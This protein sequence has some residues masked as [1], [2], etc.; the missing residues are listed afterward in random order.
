MALF[1]K[2]KK[3]ELT[4]EEQENVRVKTFLD[5]VE[6]G[7]I[8]FKEE[9]IV[10]DSMYRCIWA[11]R[12]Y[13]TTTTEQAILSAFGERSGVTLHVIT[14][15]LSGV[16]EEKLIKNASNRT[17][18]VKN[19]VT[20]VQKNITA[21]E[22]YADIDQ[23][24]RQLHRE[25]ESLFNTSV[26]IEI[27]AREWDEFRALQT[28]VGSELKRLKISYD[29]LKL[30]QKD[31]FFSV[32]PG[33]TDRFSG[34]Y[35]RAL[36]ASSVAN[37]YPFLFSGK[38]CEK[39]FTLG[40]D[41]SGGTVIMDFNERS[42][43]I[44]NP[45]I[46]ILGMPGMGKSFAAKTI[47][48]N[49]ALQ[50]MNIIV[51]DPENEYE[52]LT[53]N[54]GGTYLDLMSG[55][56]IINVLEPKT[57]TTAD[58]GETINDDS[59]TTDTY[60]RKG[61][62]SQH[63]SFL[64]DFFKTYKNLSLKQLDALEII[65]RDLYK[66][67]GFD[68][69]TDFSRVPKTAFPILSDLWDY[70]NYQ[71]DHFDEAS[72]YYEKSVLRDLRLALQSICEGTQ[73][74]Y[75]NGHTNITNAHILTFGMKGILDADAS[76]RGAMLFNCLSYLSDMMLNQRNTLGMIDELYLFLGNGTN[77]SMTAC[78]YIR[79]LSK[80]CRKFDSSLCLATQNVIDLL[81]SDVAAYT[82]PLLQNPAHKLLFHL[83]NIDPEEICRTLQ[84]EPSEYKVIASP[85]RGRC[86]FMSGAER[87]SLQIQVPTWKSDLYGSAGGK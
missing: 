9:Y 76:L 65:L 59:V 24:I 60:R 81:R 5:M 18:N 48:T 39:G 84:I 44:T 7:T 54:L 6:P 56:Y 87:Y 47:I 66:S 30:R 42:A 21:Q 55:Q 23:M 40:K 68:D 62:L 46:L 16:E 75:F 11:V 57:F 69:T 70:M 85:H 12:S 32:M 41:T 72:S 36:P 26:F 33:G 64:R 63:I 35:S 34:Y 86:L 29:T 52:A 45:N 28:E 83:G 4:P 80:R 77:G 51:F 27:A 61:A 67:K 15:E 20:D 38:Y 13:P 10:Q 49:S 17:R 78:E 3:Q 1:K 58:D 37:F 14:K 82:I 71:Y 22:D 74:C 8:K 53:E 79:N 73:S 19:S 50:G 25:K 2:K 43:S 31:G